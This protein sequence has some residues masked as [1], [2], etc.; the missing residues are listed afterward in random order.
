[1]LSPSVEVEPWGETLL[2]TLQSQGLPHVVAC[3]ISDMNTSALERKEKKERTG[4]MK[5]LLSFMQY[6]VPSLP[7]IYDLSGAGDCANALRALCEGVP[8]E[9]R[10]RSGRSWLLA[11]NVSWEEKKDQDADNENKNTG[12]LHVTGVLRGGPFS[13]NR[14]VHLPGYGDFQVERIVSAP[15]P[16]VGRGTA[17]M[18]IEPIQLAAPD[19]D[20]DSLVSTNIPD[21]LANEQTW[22]TEEEMRGE[23]NDHDSEIIPDAKKG[24]TP[25]RVKRVPKGWSS[26]Q[27]AWIAE[28]EDEEEPED[29][30]DEDAGSDVSMDGDAP[31]LDLTA[32]GTNN[33]DEELDDEMEEL[34]EAEVDISSRRS[35]AFQDL[36]IE[37]EGRQLEEWREKQRLEAER[38]RNEKEDAEFPDEIDTPRDIPARTRFARYRG[39][40]SMRTSPWDPY[41][42][43]PRDY[44]RIFQFED[45]KRTE[46]NVKRRSEAEGYGIEVCCL[47][48]LPPVLH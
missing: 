1:M 9:L 24:T 32:E 36:D 20:A 16:R 40:R 6:F 4:V 46:R 29:D 14:L 10:W 39:L 22:P 11:E 5:S 13:A 23:I 26:Y 33:E 44:A 34:Q 21:D 15:L 47:L 25:R 41:E 48:F 27:A 35:V 19:N 2:R 12:S 28:D 18:E 30:E 3:S 7:R 8:N 38:E 45:Y 31:G 17:E 37:E 42:N 43:L